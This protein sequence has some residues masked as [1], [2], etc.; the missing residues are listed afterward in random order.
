V[1]ELPARWGDPAGAL[2]EADALLARGPAT[3][4]AV[5]PEA[6][7][8]GYVSPHGDF[9]LVRFAEPLDG[10]TARGIAALAGKHR[11]HVVGPLIEEAADGRV[12]NATVGFAPSGERVLH[13]RKRHP[14]VPERWATPGELPYPLVEIGG[15]KV[16]A[17]VCYDGHFVADEA[18]EVLRA[19]DLLL[20]PSAWVDREDTRGP[21]LQEIAAQFELAV[22]N[23]N[24]A[25]GA[26]KVPGQGGSM[27]LARGG[28]V[29]ATAH[30]GRA[31]AELRLR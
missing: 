7:L 18:A 12:Y 22:A 13:Y 27:I 14:W 23:A 4:L 24:W 2:A 1:L 21:L 10:A 26:V 11:A 31:D 30:D 9:D 15:V 28:A 29:L 3:D 17:A 25:P 5:L 16:T 6:S 20:F 8:T 19:A